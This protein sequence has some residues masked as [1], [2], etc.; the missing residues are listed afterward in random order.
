MRTCIIALLALFL[1]AGLSGC[2]KK[3][4][5]EE[6]SAETIEESGGTDMQLAN[7]FAYV[8]SLEELNELSDPGFDVLP[9]TI[10][11][12]YVPDIYACAPSLGLV[13]V[14][15][16]DPDRKG[17]SILIRKARLTYDPDGTKTDIS[18]DFHTYEEYAEVDGID[19]GYSRAGNGGLVN[20]AAWDD[21]T[22]AYAIVVNPGSDQG[23]SEEVI[24]DLI[25]TIR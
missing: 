5:P 17:S 6:K 4:T 12:T 9:D 22:Y 15:Y 25:R 20:V 13:Q 11:D 23:L 2:T 19:F 21:D 7:P 1:F 24:I 3:E 8:K 10:A 18:G 14:N 16:I